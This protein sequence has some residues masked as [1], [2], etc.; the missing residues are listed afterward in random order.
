MCSLKSGVAT[1]NGVRRLRGETLAV[2]FSVCA[3]CA[4]VKARA[5]ARVRALLGASARLCCSLCLCHCL[6]R[7]FKL[8]VILHPAFP[9]H[10]ALCRFCCVRVRQ[11]SVAPLAAHADTATLMAARLSACSLATLRAVRTPVARGGSKL[12]HSTIV[13]TAAQR[14]CKRLCTFCVCACMRAHQRLCAQCVA[15]SHCCALPPCNE[16]RAPSIGGSASKGSKR[17][18]VMTPGRVKL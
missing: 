17:P 7:R 12:A 6:F 14:V 10:P 8:C 13:A 1:T 11:L 15:D 5:L 16:R 18:V 3:V 9:C 2:H 4:W